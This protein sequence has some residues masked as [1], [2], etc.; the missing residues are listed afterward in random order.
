MK[1]EHEHCCHFLDYTRDNVNVFARFYF[2][3]VTTVHTHS[4]AHTHAQ[5]RMHMVFH[6]VTRGKDGGSL[7]DSTAEGETKNG[8]KRKQN[9]T[10]LRLLTDRRDKIFFFY[11]TTLKIFQ[12]QHES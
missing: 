9:S 12:I 3:L 7:K 5:K 4:Q 1:G 2:C 11:R 6:L 10:S 8:R